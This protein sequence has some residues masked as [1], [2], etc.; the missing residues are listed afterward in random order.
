MLTNMP[1]SQELQAATGQLYIVEGTTQTAVPVPGLLAQSAPP[2]AAR[3][4]NRDSLFIHLSLS[5]SLEETAVLTQDLLDNISRS[6]YQSSGSVTAALR[7]AV[8]AAN[9]RL[10][11]LNLSG[12]A[13]VHEGA[14]TCAVLRGGELFMVQTGEALALL[15][16]NFGIERL[17]PAPP[18]RVTPLGRSAG[19]DIR[20]FHHRLQAGSLLL[21]ADPRIAHW[22]T[23]AL[24]PAL[25]DAEIETGLAHL[26]QA[27]GADSARLLLVEFT[28]ELE[29]AP[30]AAPT[31]ATLTRA[32]EDEP[33]P[34]P[35]RER[36]RLPSVPQRARQPQ[37]ERPSAP[38]RQRQRQSTP[39]GAPITTTLETGARKATSEAAMGL[40]RFTG[41]LADLLGR[42]RPPRDENE[43]K[44]NWGVPAAIAVIIPLILA[45]VVGSVYIQRGRG[46]RFAEIKVEIGQNLGLAAAAGEDEALAVNHYEAVL[47]LAAEAETI[48]PGDPEIARLRQQAQDEMDRIHD[49]TRLTARPL[50]TFDET[51]GLT[52]VTLQE[53]FNG[54]VY[55][56]DG[57]NGQVYRHP[58]DESYQ[59]AVAAPETILF[60][61]QAV[62][63]HIVHNVIDIFWRP[64]GNHVTRDGLA[65]LDSVGALLTFYPDFSQ[66]EAVPLGFASNWQLPRAITPFAERLYILDTGARQVW[67]YFPEGDGFL[68]KDDELTIVF[69]ENPEL[70]KATDIAIYSED[71]SLVVAYGDGRLRYYDTRSGRIAWDEKSLLESGLNSPL[72]APTAVKMVGKGLNASIFVADPGSG[73]IIEIS[74]GG[75]PLAQY[76]ATNESGQELFAN[77]TDF[78]VVKTPLRVFVTAGNVL[79]T[80]VQE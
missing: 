49:I 28:D 31:S 22:P 1:S 20:F 54:G 59:I 37:P 15:G 46:Q 7:Q 24:S 72:V 56:L 30:V 64:R 66:T 23:A 44:P 80:A 27:V 67:K 74:R 78:D 2:K 70:D 73:R 35:R 71:G 42:L 41:W 60:A 45:L 14:I 34:Q 40:A 8:I 57:V 16:H 32:Q 61:G 53:G 79:Y 17:P 63:S 25:V 9:Q 26:T 69:N 3:S 5:G 58:T 6:Y 75:T 21:L 62:G 65:A 33:T 12:T 43:K 18:D 48:R 76:R 36:S 52:A 10:L 68:Q 38:Q 4:R 29:D 47:T 50:H 55:T 39:L 19:L 11:R 77:I 13:A 51:V